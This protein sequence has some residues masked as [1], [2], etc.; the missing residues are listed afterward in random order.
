[1][2]ID[3]SIIIRFINDDLKKSEKNIINNLIKKNKKIK[4][5][6][7]ELKNIKFALKKEFNLEKKVRMPGNL[8]E[9]ISKQGKKNTGIYF[10]NK[11]NN[12]FKIAAGI[13]LIISFGAI[14]TLPN[15]TYLSQDP[16]SKIKRNNQVHIFYKEKNLNDFISKN[17][18]CSEPEEYIDENGENVYAVHC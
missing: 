2:K 13:F 9:K 17:R 5:R 15:K 11:F 16:I 6:Y 3:D 1:M 7:L 18:N 4:S 8:F 14:I 12:L 10:S